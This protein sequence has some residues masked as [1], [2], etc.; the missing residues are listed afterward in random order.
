MVGGT[1]GTEIWQKHSRLW[2][3]Q[4]QKSCVGVNVLENSLKANVSGAHGKGKNR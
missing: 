2:E 1:S 3:Q 4:V